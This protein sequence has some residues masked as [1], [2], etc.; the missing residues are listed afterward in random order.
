MGNG[1]QLSVF[2]NVWGLELDNF[3]TISKGSK[4]A[5]QIALCGSFPKFSVI[6]LSKLIEVN[7]RSSRRAHRS[8]PFRVRLLKPIYHFCH[9]A[10]AETDMPLHCGSPSAGRIDI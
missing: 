9:R 2:F 3:G 10:G 1:I 5:F 8:L 4:D 6:C 7:K